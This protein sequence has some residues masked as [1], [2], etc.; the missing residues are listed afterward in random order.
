M[1]D[2]AFAGR[3]LSGERIQ[4]SGR[5]SSG[6]L[7]TP[8]DIFLIPFS[9][10]WCGIVV[11]PMWPLGRDEFRSASGVPAGMSLMPLLFPLLFVTVG[12]YL[13]VGR[14]AVDAWVRSGTAYAVTNQRILITKSGIFSRF[15]AIS[16][17]R[18]PET[19][20]REGL[21][22]RGT[23]QFGSQTPFWIG[24]TYGMW[25]PALD[26]TPQFLAIPDARGVFDLIQKQKGRSTIERQA[27]GATV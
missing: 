13:L 8:R 7:F 20:L 14:F 9:L 6:L 24:R 4:W 12:L 5:P 17:D 11:S 23:I 27:S 25:S 16:L 26:P 15:I 1:A 10:F 19:Q 3:L 18:L 2:D 22:G 21:G